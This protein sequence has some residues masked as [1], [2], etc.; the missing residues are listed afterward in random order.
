M[1]TGSK[2]ADYTN[3]CVGKRKE[4]RLTHLHRRGSATLEVTL[5][6]RVNCSRQGGFEEL[7]DLP[8]HR[9]GKWFSLEEL[10]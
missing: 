8:N 10:Y 6:G 3:N 2:P 1:V 9:R 7:G 5:R 4:I